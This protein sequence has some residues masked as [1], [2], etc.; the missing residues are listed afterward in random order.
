MATKVARKRS[1]GWARAWSLGW[2]RRLV[3]L[4]FLLFIAKIAVEKAIV[5]EEST[6]FVP[7]PEAYSPFGG[8]EGLYKFA[9]TSGLFIAHTHWSNLVLFAGVVLM[10][11]VTKSTFCG[12]ICP[13]GALQEWLGAL[14]RRLGIPRRQ[15]PTRIDRV[16]RYFKY[17]VL[18]WATVGSATVG[19]M[20]FRDVDPYH[21]LVEATA[22]G[23]GSS[24]VVL[25][26]TL[27]ASLFV[28]RPWCKY[29]CPLGATLGLLGR[30][31]L[32]KVERD[33]AGCR[34]CGLCDRKCPMQVAVSTAGRVASPECNNCLIC[35]E[36]CPH[37][38]LEPKLIGVRGLITSKPPKIE[39]E[40]NAA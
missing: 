22:V 21:A 31:S 6:T 38:A 36:A 24:T 19:V 14:G 33:A 2:V 39:G 4:Y 11:L 16:L 27:V 9:T 23:F 35:T 15:L 29:A 26:G 37:G 13:F 20:V 7:S 5:G 12:W 8:F 25:I 32:V 30:L 17:A 10:T 40:S 34:D 28:D 1:K 18:V 3:Q